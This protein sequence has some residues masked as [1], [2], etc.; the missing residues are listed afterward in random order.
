MR[1]SVKEERELKLE[2]FR[3]MQ[4]HRIAGVLSYFA[5]LAQITLPLDVTQGGVKSTP[6][7]LQ[8]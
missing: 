7:S 6:S 2:D 4:L 3:E 1:R 8:L 5:P